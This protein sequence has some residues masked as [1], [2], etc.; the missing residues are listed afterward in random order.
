MTSPRRWQ[1]RYLERF[2]HCR[3]DWVGGTAEFY[4]LLQRHILRDREILELGPGP[5]NKFTTFLS[6]TFKAVDGLDVDEDA[7]QNTALRQVFI[8]DGTRWPLSDAGYDAVV[9]NYVLEHLSDPLGTIA[10]AYRALRPGGVFAFRTPNLWHY[11]SFVSWLSP[12]WFHRMVANRLR[13]QPQGSH[14]PY[15]TYYRMNRCRTLR[16]LARQVGFEEIELSLVEKEP[17]YG[18]SSRILFLLFMS[19]ERLVNSSDAFEHIR[20]NIFGAFRKPASQ[21]DGLGPLLKAPDGE[22]GHNPPGHR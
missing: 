18:M 15:P 19:Y 17:A 11:V 3:P 8:Y 7:R 9:S 4:Q 12:H 6:Q 20:G 5:S 2:Y 21:S 22:M 10:E 1:D 13:N 16:T 14:D